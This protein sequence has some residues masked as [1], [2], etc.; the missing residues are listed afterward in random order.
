MPTCTH[1]EKGN[2]GKVADIKK[3]KLKTDYRT[4]FLARFTLAQV[5]RENYKVLF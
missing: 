2:S 1:K 5:A 4:L 3:V